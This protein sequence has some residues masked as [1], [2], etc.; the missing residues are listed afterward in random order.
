MSDI[1][2]NL[3]LF[4]VEEG[5]GKQSTKIN[6]EGKITLIGVYLISIFSICNVFQR[7]HIHMYGHVCMYVCVC[8][9]VCVCAHARK[10]AHISSTV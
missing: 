9:C 2:M 1:T 5:E 8:V 7:M 4:R 6:D 10:Q 3:F